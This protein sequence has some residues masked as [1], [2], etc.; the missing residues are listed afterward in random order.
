MR[1]T[2]Q[3]ADW[4][5]AAAQDHPQR[6]FLTTPEGRTLTYGELGAESGR[7]AVAMQQLGVTSGDRVA[8]QMDKSVD[9]VL[10]YVACLRLGAVFVPINVA[11]TPAELDYFLRDCQPQLAVIRPVDQAL[12]EPV[13]RA[14]GVPCVQTL[15]AGGEGTLASLKNAAPDLPIIRGGDADSPAAIVY[16]SGTTGRSK[17]AVLTRTNLASNAGV[18]AQTWRFTSNDVLLHVLPLFHVHGLFAAINTVLAS[19]SALLLFSKFDAQSTVERMR[20]ASVFMGVPTHYTRLLQLA[21]LNRE[22]TAGM[23]LFVSGSAPLL[24]A[25]HQEFLDRTGHTILER[26]GMTETLMNTSNPYAGRRKPGSVGMPL[27]GTA[28]RVVLSDGTTASEPNVT[29]AVEIKG[30]NVFAGYWRAAQ[31]TRAEFTADGW[32]KSGDLGCIDEEGYV[33]IVGRAKDLVISG[34]YNV[35]PK[36]VE[37]ALDE[38]GGVEESA[39]FGVPHPDFGEAVTAAVV[40]KAGANLSEVE[41]IRS[42]QTVLARYKVPKRVLC[43]NELPR[44][45]MGKVQKNVLRDTYCRLF[46][47][48]K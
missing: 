26:Y 18:L 8:V 44:N 9:A 3:I 7:F 29:G 35:Y 11:N 2:S 25:T 13:A 30:P 15:G 34:G 42:L 39:V 6:L 10:L 45:S 14:A 1:L 40:A 17:G 43:I 47:G 36:E 37:L 22:S 19:R 5:E 27:A 41:I 4:I 38:L 24:A 46:S 32:F 16:T 20:S 31:K 48:D 12:L 21:A 23:R 28:V 33:H